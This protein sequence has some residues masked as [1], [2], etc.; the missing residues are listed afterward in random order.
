MDALLPLLPL[1]RAPVKRSSH[2]N[3]SLPFPCLEGTAF[4]IQFFLDFHF[5]HARSYCGKRN[6]AATEL[7]INL[8]DNSFLDASGFG[9]SA[10][11]PMKSGGDA[12]V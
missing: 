2:R 5:M 4:P 3:C 8:N 11:G 12:G 1:L 10:M 7:F 9:M 6:A